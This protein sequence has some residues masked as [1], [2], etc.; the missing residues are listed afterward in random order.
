MTKPSDNR[1]FGDNFVK[2]T[3][4]FFGIGYFPWGPGTM[5]SLAG[6]LI[7]WFTGDFFWLPLLIFLVLG[8]AVCRP[9]I[10]VLNSGDPSSFVMDE[11]VGVMIAAASIPHTWQFYLAAFVLFR[12]FDIAKPWPIS[13][14]QKSKLP[15]AIM[16][17]DILAGLFA[18]ILIQ[19]YLYFA[20]GRA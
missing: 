15:R 9:A 5:G 12:I 3:A 8:F 16:A 1:L 20:M 19:G 18:N 2:I 14:I 6:I 10:R 7:A 11:V 13:V 17:D 4:T